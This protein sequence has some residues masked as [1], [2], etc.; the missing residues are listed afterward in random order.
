MLLNVVSRVRDINVHNL[1]SLV[2]NKL[3]LW[4]YETT[5]RLDVES[6]VTCD[7][8]SV[9]LWVNLNCVSLD[10]SLTSL[11]VTLRLDTLKLEKRNAKITLLIPKFFNK[12]L[13]ILP[14]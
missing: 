7:N 6:C 12:F 10:K 3:I 2:C 5:I 1:A 9:K 14:G 13:Y 11:V 8:L 4:V